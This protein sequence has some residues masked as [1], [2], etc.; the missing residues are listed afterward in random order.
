MDFQNG[1]CFREGRRIPGESG[2]LVSG[3]AAEQEPREPERGGG[4][5]SS[6]TMARDLWIFISE[7]KQKDRPPAADD[8]EL[9][10]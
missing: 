6:E 1:R 8:A 5:C 9:G 7:H 10:I 4:T 2:V 3:D